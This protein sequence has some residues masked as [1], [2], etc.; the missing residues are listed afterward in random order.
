MKTMP[1]ITDEEIEQIFSSEDVPRGDLRLR[2]SEAKYLLEL[3]RMDARRNS[4]WPWGEKWVH[5]M[6]IHIG[7]ELARLVKELK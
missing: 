4:H 7:G 6:R 5:L 2:H 3:V 1:E